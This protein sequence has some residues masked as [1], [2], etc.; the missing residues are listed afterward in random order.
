[1]IYRINERAASNTS[2]AAEEMAQ[3]EVKIDPYTEDMVLNNENLARPFEQVSKILVNMNKNLKARRDVA[4]T[5]G[6]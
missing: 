5:V 3:V 1:M 2:V 4:Q 6:G